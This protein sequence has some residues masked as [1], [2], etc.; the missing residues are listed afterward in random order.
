MG[1]PFFRLILSSSP[2]FLLFFRIVAVGFVG[3]LFRVELGEP[4]R[5]QQIVPCNDLFHVGNMD[6]ISVVFGKNLCKKTFQLFRSRFRTDRLFP[7]LFFSPF[8]SFPLLIQKKKA[9]RLSKT[10]PSLT[11]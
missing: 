7:S 4:G 10:P 1:F 3:L 5:N 6:P 8:S 11:S 9:L 2:L